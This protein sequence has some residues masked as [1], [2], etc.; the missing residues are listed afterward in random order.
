MSDTAVPPPLTKQCSLDLPDSGT[1]VCIT[2]TEPSPE[3][4]APAISRR[5]TF[6][7]S[8]ELPRVVHAL[9]H[10]ESEEY[11][12]DSWSLLNYLH[13]AFHYLLLMV[14]GFSSPYKD[15]HMH[16]VTLY[17]D[18]SRYYKLKNL[19]CSHLFVLLRD[20]AVFFSFLSFSFH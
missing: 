19:C 13:P 16:S 1:S 6:R 11:E 3:S 8:S 5:S 4:T 14:V 10:R 18:T 9:V 2:V 7:R 15:L 17:L 20:I 12:A